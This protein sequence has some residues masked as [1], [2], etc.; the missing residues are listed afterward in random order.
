TSRSRRRTRQCFRAASAQKSMSALAQRNPKQIAV[1]DLANECVP[2]R[3]RAHAD[4]SSVIDNARALRA[5]DFG[6]GLEPT[7]RDIGQFAVPAGRQQIEANLVAS[8]V[9][10]CNGEPR[11]VV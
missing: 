8:L 4:I 10:L 9:L 7:A 6:E 5:S 1:D 3:R 11:A 2:I